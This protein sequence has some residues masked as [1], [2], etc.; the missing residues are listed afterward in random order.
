MYRTE[1][2][3]SNRIFHLTS[4]LAEYDSALD[5]DFDGGMEELER[6]LAELRLQLA[7]D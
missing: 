1:H 5:P 4:S 7:N 2:H 3:L 6:Q